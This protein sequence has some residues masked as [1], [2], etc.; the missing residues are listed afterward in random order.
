MK[1]R[2]M[3][4]IGRMLSLSA[5]LFAL[6]GTISA[7]NK[8]KPNIIFILTDDQGY[9][10][11]ACHGNPWIK[12]PNLDQLHSESIRFTNYH[13]GTTSAPTRSGLMTG[14]YCNKVGVWHT[15]N[16]RSLLSAEEKTLA[17]R[18]KENG[19]ATAIF[20]KW[21]LGDNYPFRPQDRG[22]EETLVHKGG[23]VG[24]QP[25]FWNNDYFNDT[26]FRN[27]IPEKFD[28]YCTDIWFSEALK[29]IEKNKAQPFFCYIALNAPHSPYYVAE[30]YSVAY[31]DNPNIPFPNFYGMIANIDENIGKLRVS[32][33][34]LGI[35][36]NTILIFM[37]DNGTSGGVQFDKEGNLLSG[38]NA[39]MKGIKGSPY[40]G[41]HR[42]PFFIHWPE[43][44][45][46]R[47]K[48][49]STLSSYV[50]FTPTLLD[51]CN[52]PVNIRDFDGISLKPIIYGEKN[53]PERILF[54]D[55]QRE[56]FLVKGKQCAV[57]TD[58]W[59]LIGNEKLYDMIKDPGQE[60]NVIA[61]F[62]DVSNHLKVAY[63]EWWKDVSINASTYQRIIAGNP[64]ENP[65]R[66][67][68]HDQHVAEGYPAWDQ[69]M[70]R[71]GWGKIG[72]WT[73]KVE[74]SGEYEIELCR[75]PKES[76]LTVT[77]K[78]ATVEECIF[79][80]ITYLEGQSLS[81]V[82][83]V[84][85]IGDDVQT[86]PVQAN[87]TSSKFT[88]HLVKGNYELTAK[89]I[90]EQRAEYPAYYVYILKRKELF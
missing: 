4:S 1:Y 85:S 8:E 36:K 7:E 72:Y 60:T 67:N 26:Y 70:V 61:E 42:V 31:R 68:S 47:G 78:A 51:L 86:Q 82:N 41:G 20:G 59:R 49:I 9:G 44:N 80:T 23:G 22:F 15:I 21:H 28:G 6:Y 3:P 2:T 37:T 50:D 18:L 48:D 69:S 38:Y 62:P 33:C 84:V 73:I 75:W 5:G 54:T 81:I 24:Q 89:F 16:G 74:T 32:L 39:G 29:Y 77:D 55:T 66:L 88:Y 65:V 87:Q 12:T 63:E 25:D 90:D 76:N 11:L 43:G 10:D 56:E 83:A 57:M 64:S 17:N 34:R 14:Q 71:K 13:V 27:G 46:T 19:Y 53:W 30:K 58:R 35:D 45:L 52:M 40:E 79:H